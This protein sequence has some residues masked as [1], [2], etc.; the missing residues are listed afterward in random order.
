MLWILSKMLQYRKTLNHRKHEY[1]T[2]FC[3][4]KSADINSKCNIFIFLGFFLTI[5]EGEGGHNMET[6][7][8]RS[9]A[10]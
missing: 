2:V 1:M 10:T 3:F 5:I 6:Q 9:T 8:K 4:Y 7:Y